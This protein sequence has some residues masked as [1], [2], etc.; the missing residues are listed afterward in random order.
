MCFPG[1]SKNDFLR[2]RGRFQTPKSRRIEFF[3]SFLAPPW[4]LRGPQNRPSGAK[5]R[6]FVKRFSVVFRNLEPTCCQ[7]RFRSA[8]GHHFG[9]FGMDF[10][11]IWMDF[12]IMFQGFW[13]RSC[14]SICRMPTP[15]GTKRNNGKRHKHADNYRN[16]QKSNA[17]KKRM[18]PNSD[19]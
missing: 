4:I 13:S 5:N 15:P 12:G 7:G 17:T 3:G 11:W 9:R 8:H 16:M 10:G 2:P 6:I 18:N 19:R 1:P 14:T